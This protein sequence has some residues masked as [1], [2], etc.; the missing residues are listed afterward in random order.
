MSGI[1]RPIGIWLLLIPCWQ[2]IALALAQYRKAPDA[3]DLWLVIGF[4]LGAVLMRA[5]G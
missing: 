2:G 3:Y 1:D 5:A 4:T